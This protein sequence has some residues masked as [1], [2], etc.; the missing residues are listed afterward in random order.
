MRYWFQWS[1]NWWQMRIYSIYMKTSWVLSPYLQQKLKEIDIYQYMMMYKTWVLRDEVADTQRVLMRYWIWWWF[2]RLQMRLSSLYMKT[3][4]V[5]SPY[6]QQ[7]LK[8]IDIYQ[9]M[10]IYKIW[11]FCDEVDDTQLVLMRFWI[12]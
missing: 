4:W 7:K 6:L 9:Y 10:R 1:I 3:S 8:E 12:Y 11:V 5:L 2:I